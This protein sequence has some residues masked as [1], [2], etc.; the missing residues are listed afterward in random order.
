MNPLHPFEVDRQIKT[1][2]NAYSRRGPKSPWTETADAEL[3]DMSDNNKEKCTR[4]SKD[5]KQYPDAS[6][7][8]EP[9]H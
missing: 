6:A 2:K 3:G 4:N 1:E 9:E 7:V 5:L 8:A